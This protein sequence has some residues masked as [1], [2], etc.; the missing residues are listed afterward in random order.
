MYPFKRQKKWRRSCII[1]RAKLLC[2]AYCTRKKEQTSPVL[3][4]LRGS[5]SCAVWKIC[6]SRHRAVPTTTQPMLR[7]RENETKEKKPKTKRNCYIW[8]GSHFKRHREC[9]IL[10]TTLNVKRKAT[11]R[12]RELWNRSHCSVRVF[13]EIFV[14]S[15]PFKLH[16]N[17]LRY[18]FFFLFP[19]GMSDMH[20]YSIYIYRKKPLNREWRSRVGNIQKKLQMPRSFSFLKNSQ[21]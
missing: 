17:P 9:E 5:V 6:S 13:K 20:F 4:S 18:R 10:E 3:R 14:V 15:T 8:P 11:R 19:P 16:S 1:S 12:R 21:K 7:R 2:T